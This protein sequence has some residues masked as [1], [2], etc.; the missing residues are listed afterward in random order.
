M[1]AGESNIHASEHASHGFLRSVLLVFIALRLIFFALGILLQRSSGYFNS[2]SIILLIIPLFWLIPFFLILKN[3]KLG[4]L[5]SI[6]FALVYLG[7]SLIG[8]PLLF[9]FF[10]PNFIIGLVILAASIYLAASGKAN[11]ADEFF[12]DVSRPVQLQ[13]SGASISAE[14]FSRRL[15]RYSE[16]AISKGLDKV[17]VKTQEYEPSGSS[18]SWRMLVL[19]FGIKLVP[20]LTYILQ[21]P[22]L[23]PINMLHLMITG[24]F[25]VW[26]TAAVALPFISKIGN[27][28]FR[29]VLYFVCW[30]LVLTPP[31]V[32]IGV[33]FGPKINI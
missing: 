5:L 14:E 1:P 17:E 30:Y 10:S 11:V 7:R 2:Q 18:E 26:I 24:L 13:Q 25:P 12:S 33:G 4:Y 16:A 28:A 21:I 27:P 32:I 31:M 29:K 6:P 22:L 23:F 8:V 15:N 19:A 20:L 9:I 3:N